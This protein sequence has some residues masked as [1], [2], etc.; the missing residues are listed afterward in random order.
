MF[1]NKNLYNDVIHIYNEIFDDILVP[2]EYLQNKI[3]SIIQDNS[4][5]IG[6]QIRTGDKYI[7]TNQNDFDGVNGEKAHNALQVYTKTTS[8][9]IEQYLTMILRNIKEDIIKNKSIDMKKTKIFITSDYNDIMQLVKDIWDNDTTL[10]NNDVVQHI[11]RN[12]I[13]K[14]FS[15]TFVDL[16]ILSKY[17]NHLYISPWSNYG[18]ISYLSNSSV[19]YAKN[20]H[21][22]KTIT[23]NEIINNVKKST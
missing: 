15:K 19:I 14:D 20:I 2:T 5:I 13:Y 1:S 23:R 21:N 16:I 6:I 3:N 4:T 18:K 10:Y 11:D 7:I 22:L 8:D 12:P 9:N 17:C